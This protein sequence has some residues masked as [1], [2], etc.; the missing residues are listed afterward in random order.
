MKR[1]QEWM[2][3]KV[4]FWS[5]KAINRW[6]RRN[7]GFMYL[8]ELR[9]KTWREA[10]SD[11]FPKAMMESAEHFNSAMDSEVEMKKATPG[12]SALETLELI[13]LHK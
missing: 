11:K 1:L 7:T 13:K 3:G 6:L 9:L 5:Y 10:N 8:F 2:D 4:Y 12:R